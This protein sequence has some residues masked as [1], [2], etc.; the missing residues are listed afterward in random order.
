MKSQQYV[1]VE[2][3]SAYSKLEGESFHLADKKKQV[4]SV[5]YANQDVERFLN[6]PRLDIS[7]P[8]GLGV[9][10]IQEAAILQ[11]ISVCENFEERKLADRVR[12]KTSRNYSEKSISVSVIDDEILNDQSEFLLLDYLASCGEQRNRIL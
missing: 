9:P 12:R 6:Q 2:Q 7:I 1:N 8:F 10:Q 11:A 4:R 3:V 5:R